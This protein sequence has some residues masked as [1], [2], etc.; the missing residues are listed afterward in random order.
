VALIIRV[1]AH[2]RREADKS[3]A[4]SPE[5]AVRDHVALRGDHSTSVGCE[6]EPGQPPVVAELL[7]RVIGTGKHVQ[8][9]CI[10]NRGDRLG[11][12]HGGRT[13]GELRW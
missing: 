4:A 3:R 7:C 10:E 1:Y 2:P 5:I 9:A 8:R 12:C 6:L 11:V 13:D